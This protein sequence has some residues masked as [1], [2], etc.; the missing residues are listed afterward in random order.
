MSDEPQRPELAK[1]LLTIAIPTYNR[2]GCLRELLFA[3]ADQLKNEPRVELLISDNASPDSTPDVVRDSENRGLSLRYI[4]NR[5]NVGPDANFL[6]CFEQARGKY[7]WIFSDDDLIVPS[8]I[9]RI[10]SYCESGQYDLMWVSNYPFDKSYSPR[11]VPTRRDAI[12]ISN[13][14]AYAKRLHIFFTFISGNII[15]KETV[16]AAGPQPFSSLIGTGFVQLGWMFTALNRFRRGLY[17]RE[18]LVAMRNNNTGG[19][20]LFEVF[21][22]T[23]DTITRGWLRS[24]E[25]GRIVM[26]GTVQRFWPM[27]LLEYRKRSSAF[28]DNANPQLTLAPLY[29]NNFRYWVSAYPVIVLPLPLAEVWVL[30]VRAINLIDKALDFNCFR[31]G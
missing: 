30:F 7:V 17:I 3:L 12:E 14:A 21:G 16:L 11:A 22:Y 24:P 6:Q 2:S 13:P 1:P 31:V 18:K 15:N 19:Y 27:M 5:E 4:R 8:G 28:T 20:K 25:L 29:R 9:E 26:N 10:L 23:L